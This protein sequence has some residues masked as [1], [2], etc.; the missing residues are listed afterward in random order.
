[1]RDRSHSAQLS[2]SLPS[3]R[4]VSCVDVNAECDFTCVYA[5]RCSPRVSCSELGTVAMKY[6][7]FRDSRD[8]LW[9]VWEVEPSSMERRVRNDPERCPRVDRRDSASAPRI[10]VDDARFA[11]G[12]L[13]FESRIEKRR[14]CPV[15]SQW[16]SLTD[17]ELA[18]LVSQ[19]VPT[20]KH[21]A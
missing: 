3:L 7:E 12:W 4:L 14:L 20:T 18:C 16:E 10:R 2:A 13:A 19:A 15:P 9:S 1:M 8:E 6:R 5:K 11:H 21:G 17:A